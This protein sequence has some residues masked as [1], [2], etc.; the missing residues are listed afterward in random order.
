MFAYSFRHNR[1]REIPFFLKNSVRPSFSLAKGRS[2]EIEPITTMLMVRA[3]ERSRRYLKMMRLPEDDAAA[4]NNQPP[5][6]CLASAYVTTARLSNG[7]ISCC[8]RE[9]VCFSAEVVRL[10]LKTIDPTG[11]LLIVVARS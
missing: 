8:R 7:Y 11:Y 1:L 2:E 4:D 10:P 9:F 5:G 6:D 3:S